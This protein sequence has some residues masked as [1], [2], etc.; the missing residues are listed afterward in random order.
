MQPLVDPLEADRMEVS[1]WG[2]MP[3]RAI[4]VCHG[5]FWYTVLL[6]QAL[7][8]HQS[9]LKTCM[10]RAKQYETKPNPT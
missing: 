9:A 10:G 1:L 4:F 6:W 3:G 7:C 5:Q 8:R 2:G